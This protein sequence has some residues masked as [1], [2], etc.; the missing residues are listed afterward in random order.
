MPLPAGQGARAL[1]SCWQALCEERDHK[2]TVQNLEKRMSTRRFSSWNITQ[3]CFGTTVTASSWTGE[4]KSC[5]AKFLLFLF[6]SMNHQTSNPF[7][8]GAVFR[9][10]VTSTSLALSIAEVCVRN[11]F[12]PGESAGVDVSAVLARLPWHT[13]QTL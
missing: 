3:V 13:P 7:Q 4:V 11:G 2:T 12:G 10:H 5:P 1:A 6:K 9:L 8:P